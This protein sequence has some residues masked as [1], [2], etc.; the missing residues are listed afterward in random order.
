MTISFRPIVKT[1]TLL[2]T[3]L[4]RPHRGFACLSEWI[5]CSTLLSEAA[6]PIVERLNKL[7]NKISFQSKAGHP[8]TDRL[9]CSCDLDL[10]PT[11]LAYEL[12]LSKEV[13]ESVW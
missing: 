1:D 6:V 11:T 7:I 12:D 8:R 9:S 2:F 13:S 3:Y 10:D 5:R 4:I